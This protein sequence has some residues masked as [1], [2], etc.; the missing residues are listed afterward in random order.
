MTMRIWITGSNGMLA[1]DV[2]AV[3][4]QGGHEVLATDRELDI[5][6]EAAVQSFVQDHSIEA[7]VNCAAY[8]A[9]DKAEA[10]KEL[11]FAINA[12]GPKNLALAAQSVQALLVHI[13]TDYV[14][15]GAYG[16]PLLEDAPYEPLNVYGESKQAGEQAIVS[17]CD[18]HVILRTAWLY[19]L[20]GANFVKTMLK[21]MAQK[22]SMRVV[23]DQLGAP[24]WSVDLASCIASILRQLQHAPAQDAR[25]GIYHASGQGIT[26][27]YGF[28]QEIMRLGVQAGLL[29]KAITVQPCNSS[30]FPVPAKRPAWSVLSKTKLEQNFSFY[31]PFW[32]ASLQQY[33]Q[34][35]KQMA[36]A[37]STANATL[38][39][40]AAQ[41]LREKKC[42]IFDLDGTVFLGDQP[43]VPTVRYIRSQ[44]E[45]KE[46]KES[47]GASAQTHP[48]TI[49]FLTNNTSTTPIEYVSKLRR[50]G[51][52]IQPKHILTP[53][54]P[55]LE[56]LQM[57][58]QVLVLANEKVLEYIKSELPHMELEAAPEQAE[59]VV[60]CFDDE[61]T[62]D[63]IKN[64]TQILQNPKHFYWAT[65]ADVVCPTAQGPVPDVGSFMALIQSV[66]G[67]VPELIFGKP[68]LSLIQQELERFAPEEI[69]ISGDRIYTDQALAL[70]GG[71]DFALVLS[72]E[73]DVEQLKTMQVAPNF[74]LQNWG[75]LENDS[76]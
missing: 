27:W 14:L 19:G 29:P 75:D 2:L 67:R 21:F 5:C 33:M 44:I 12:L 49:R 13:S 62:Y 74:V 32:Q 66:T 65:H 51:L 68:D 72:G 57:C 11:A 61:L 1:Q 69:V 30:E 73:T 70:A 37:P 35:E 9:V 63:K 31:F 39:A 17:C 46:A 55:L 58:E 6:D 52:N 60:L 23:D 16:T 53:F 7:I 34:L 64:A 48:K 4:Q 26:N 59:G 24:T 54:R 43:I 15:S 10:D 36:S 40:Q 3:L 41:K 45:A 28:A 25:Y 8:T 47:I 20:H 71:I 18:R 56:H 22:E 76:I 38:N 42:L 50:M